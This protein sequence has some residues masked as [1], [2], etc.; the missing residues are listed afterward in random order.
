M[1]VTATPRYRFTPTVVMTRKREITSSGGTGN[2]AA[3]VEN[4]VVVPQQV[5]R[6]VTVWPAIPLP[7]ARPRPARAG[8]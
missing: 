5:E 7:G 3:A 6:G 4:G 8:V 1:C 2:G